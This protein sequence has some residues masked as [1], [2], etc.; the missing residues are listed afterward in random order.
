MVLEVPFNEDIYK[1]Q[2]NLIL[3]LYWNK[4]LKK[5]KNNLI[6]SIVFFLLGVF[7]IYG[8]GNVGYVFVIISIY[9]FLEFYKIN[10]AYQKSKKEF[11]K[12]VS[13]EIKGQI[14]SNQ[15]SI[16]EFNDTYFRYK[17][18]KLDVKINWTAFKSYAIIEDNLFLNLNVGNQSSYIIAKEEIGNDSF[19]EVLNFVDD[20]IKRTSH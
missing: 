4:I 14:E 20:K 17:D 10:T 15:N 16:W 6:I 11:Q 8:K 12:I 9:G 13:D 19:Q 7:A 3:G 5:H 2:T 1:K 18:Y